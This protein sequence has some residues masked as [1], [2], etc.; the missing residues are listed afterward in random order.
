VLT[1]KALFAIERNLERPLRLNGL[2]EACGVSPFHLA[3]AFGEATGFSVM[4]YVRGRRLTEAAQSLASAT[5]RIF[6]ILRSMLATDR[7]KPSRARFALSSTP[8]RKWFGKTKPS[9]ISS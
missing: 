4:Q 6:S 8:P 7:T 3:H 2:A 9:R 1:N 5:R